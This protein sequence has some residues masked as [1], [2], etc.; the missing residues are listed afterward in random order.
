M[1]VRKDVIYRIY[2]SQIGKIALVNVLE[3]VIGEFDYAMSLLKK[4]YGMRTRCIGVGLNGQGVKK[5]FSWDREKKQ[6][7]E[8]SSVEDDL[9]SRQKKAA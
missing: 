6:W 9:P 2:D 7:D 1:K 8:L 4:K 3:I 5:V